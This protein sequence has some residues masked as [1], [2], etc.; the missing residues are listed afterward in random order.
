[1]MDLQ[2]TSLCRHAQALKNFEYTS[3]ELTL[4]C[5]A[6]IAESNGE[7][8][9]FVYVD[10]EAALEAARASDE[11]RRGGRALGILDGIPFAVKDNFC[12]SGMPTTCASKILEDYVAPYDA[13]AVRRLKEAG[14]VLLGKLNMDELAMGSLGA[15]SIFGPVANP[16]DPER[17]SG[18]S[19]SGSAAAVA[20]GQV[21]FALGSD[22][23]GSI[24]Q[25]AAFCG[26]TGLKP[27]Y[28]AVSRYGLVAFSSSLDCVGVVAQS[29]ADCEAVLSVLA[30]RD[31]MDATSLPY[32]NTPQEDS[33]E[34][35]RVAVVRELLERDTVSTRVKEATKSAIRALEERGARI[36]YVSLPSPKRALAAY[37][38]L[39]AVE[40]TSNLARFDGI[41]Y[42][43]RSEK[44]EDLV[45]LYSNSRGEGFGN[46]VKRRILF[47]SC[48]L[49]GDRRARYLASA[50]EA[51]KEIR[52]AMREILSR[53]DLILNPT[54]PTEA[55]PRGAGLSPA[56]RREADL[57]AV[58]ANLAGLPAISVPVEREG[59]AL[60]LGIQLT[61]GEM[62]ESLLFRAASI[63]EEALQ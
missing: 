29:V 47:G 14:A 41:R 23:G 32:E 1:M 6:R 40:A 35:L 5:L 59:E 62:R 52:A 31:E 39:S 56:Q 63:L 53:N 60:P 46:E 16:R 55:F 45:S 8:R 36:A 44:A 42:G 24:R 57:C 20:A 26:V 9:S 11:R 10:K 48:I 28:G 3:L 2:H 25:P 13:T 21:P 7:L 51:R 18:G 37:C 12:V 19:S 27:T 58:Y 30:G 50:E 15:H 43:R 34:P 33:S 22:T 54:T 38:V 17:V 49:T 61:A 4:A